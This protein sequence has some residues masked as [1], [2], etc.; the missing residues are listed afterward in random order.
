[1]KFFATV[2]LSV[3]LFV[4]S[5]GNAFACTV[6]IIK[7]ASGAAYQA[8][9][10]EFAAFINNTI[11]YFPVGSKIESI[12]P[13]GRPG[14]V[15]STKYAVLGVGLRLDK[16]AKQD[17]LMEGANDQGLTFTINAFNGSVGPKGNVQ[18]DKALSIMDFATWTLGSFRSV[19]EVKAAL[20]ANQVQL[21]LPKI[22][23]MGNVEAP[24]HY[25]IF[26]KLGA[27][28]VVE[29]INGQIMVYDNPVGVM[30]NGPAFPWHLE[31]MNNYSQ[32]SNQDRNAGQFNDLKV[33]APD[34]GN[35]LGGVPSSQT[36]PNRFVKAA[37]Y[38]N[39]VRKA[40]TPKEA[41]TTLSHIV[42]NFDRPHDLSM[43]A[44]GGMGDGPRGNTAS[45]EVTYF[46]VMNDLTQNHF[47]IR[48]INSMNYSM[49]DIRK[50]SSL[51]QVKSVPTYT[52]NEAGFDATGLFFK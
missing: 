8:R 31:N 12:A 24:F 37:F 5:I 26:D 52:V 4:S 49:I 3:S 18:S 41:I 1:M 15:F 50:L 22:A 35:A 11:S 13:S 14:M 34:S 27:G 25:A 43:D 47:Y 30:T 20:Q 16:N 23:L 39:Y 32:L 40:K 36:S 42:N 46:T 29:F 28:I 45:S 44:G 51:K 33:N 6:F 48:T 21:W 10:L 7:D 38:S 9:T 2:A 17:A 19:A